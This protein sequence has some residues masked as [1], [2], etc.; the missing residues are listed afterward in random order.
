M[1]NFEIA[2]EVVLRNEGGYVNDPKDSGGA[3][4]FGISFRYLKSL[5]GDKDA[6]G[7]ADGDIN[8]DHVIDTKD[9][10]ELTPEKAKDFYKD[11]WQANKYWRINDQEVATKIFDLAV[12]MGSKRA[13]TILQ[14]SV[15]KTSHYK[16]VLD[17]IIGEKSL[18][19]INNCYPPIL[20]AEILRQAELFYR[21]LVKN[22][23][24]NEKFLKGWLNRLYKGH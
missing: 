15:N 10:K 22:N 20:F 9:I 18:H 14:N 13:N 7:Y 12:N 8:C 5:I 23:P 1:S 6:D 11:I 19:A 2:V 3:T 21:L 16:L 24:K 17:G 4:N